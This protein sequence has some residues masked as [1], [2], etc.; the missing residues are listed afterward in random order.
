MIDGTPLNVLIEQ[1]SQLKSAQL[2]ESRRKFDNQLIWYRN[3]LYSKD[4]SKN[5]AVWN[6][7][8]FFL[9]CIRISFKFEKKKVS[10]QKL[11]LQIYAVKK[12][13]MHLVRWTIMVQ[14]SNMN[15]RLLYGNGLNRSYPIGG[16]MY[17]LYLV[18]LSSNSIISLY[19]LRRLK[20]K[21]FETIDIFRK[22]PLKEDLC[23]KQSSSA[24]LI[25]RLLIWN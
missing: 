12:E 15:A 11:P 4:V 21:T 19:I 25:C 8:S 20:I 17:V 18:P 22:Q 3:S 13:M 14:L 1:A 5:L 23:W 2:A 9:F 24:S 16:E 7:L 10:L 6:D